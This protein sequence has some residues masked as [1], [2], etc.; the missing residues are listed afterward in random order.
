MSLHWFHTNP[1][2]AVNRFLMDISKEFE[3][4]AKKEE[5]K[6]RRKASRIKKYDKQY[7]S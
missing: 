5:G 4:M 3:K 6:K 1:Q 7:K 2:E